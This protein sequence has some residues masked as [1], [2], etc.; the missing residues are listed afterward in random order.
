MVKRSKFWTVV[1]SFLPGAGHMF[2][3]F[4]KQGVSIMLTYF[5]VLAVSAWL[6]FGELWLIAPVIWFYSFFDCVNKRFSTDERFMRFEDKY[7]FEDWLKSHK[8]INLG[9]FG[10]LISVALIFVGIYIIFNNVLEMVDLSNILSSQVS[11]MLHTAMRRLP[12]V[13]IGILI[14]V[15]GVKL[16]CGKKKEI[17]DDEQN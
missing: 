5:G 2:M 16:I 9:R 12:Q 17:S 8:N 15:F 3:G 10:T 1:F 14:I 6:S 7:L 13:A 4:M 11:S